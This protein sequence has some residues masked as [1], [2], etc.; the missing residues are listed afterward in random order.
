M[1]F[2]PTSHR[3]LLWCVIGICSLLSCLVAGY[4]GGSRVIVAGATG[5]IGRQV[6]KEC[7]RRNIPTAS[8]VRSKDAITSVTAKA[9]EGSEI[10]ECNIL[11]MDEVREAYNKFQPSSTVCCLASRSGVKKEAY[12][13]DY[14]GGKNVLIAQEE[15]SSPFSA[16]KD[17]FSTSS[18]SKWF[19]PPF[20]ERRKQ[21]GSGHYVLLSAFCVGK[22]LL[23]FQFAKLQLEKEIRELTDSTGCTHS[24]VRPTAYFKS[25]DGQIENAKKGSPILFFG[26]GTCAANAICEKDLAKYLT[27]CAI[28]PESIG[29]L[30]ESRDVGGPDVPA[31]TKRDQIELIFDTLDVPLEKRKTQSLPLGIF[32]ILTA[33]FLSF[34]GLFGFLDVVTGGRAVN[35]ETA[36]MIDNDVN[37]FNSR[38]NTGH[39]VNDN[40]EFIPYYSFPLLENADIKGKLEQQ[41]SNNFLSTV[42]AALDATFWS[43]YRLSAIAKSRL[44]VNGTTF[45]NLRQKCEDAAEIVRIVRYYA[46]EPMVA[47][48]PGEVQGTK[49]LADHF[50]KIA[51]RGGQLEEVDKMTTTTGAFEL[52]VKGKVLGGNNGTIANQITIVDGDKK[53]YQ[54]GTKL[55][56]TQQR[57]NSISEQK[58]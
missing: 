20:S 6:V 58:L 9:L 48:G 30:N 10:I 32:D 21:R 54:D 49:R 17:K 5:Y 46:S 18:M 22:P 39:D 45:G 13:V 27:D 36:R 3:L 2:F 41:P 57:K 37:T 55:K 19:S 7:V 40:G 12:E 1:P 25:L 4:D 53:D 31:V 35:D 33:L 15:V 51:E 42:D 47:T 52:L 38:S 28:K 11:N 50:K 8:L 24:I 34:E 26:D 23:Q 56:V 43:S 29:M 14:G 44:P 16:S